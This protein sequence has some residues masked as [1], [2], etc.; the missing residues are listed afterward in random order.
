MRPMWENYY[1]DI[2]GLIYMI[3]STSNDLESSIK[4]F[5]NF[6]LIEDEVVSNSIISRLEI[7]IIILVNKI[8]SIY[9]IFRTLNLLK[10]KLCN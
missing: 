6:N 1:E 10:K 7:P 5:S 8:V 2:D 3:D 9:N 4:T